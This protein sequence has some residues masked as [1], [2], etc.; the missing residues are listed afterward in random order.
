MFFSTQLLES[1]ELIFVSILA[2]FLH[3]TLYNSFV[4]LYHWSFFISW[5]LSFDLVCWLVALKKKL[6][7][8]SQ[9]I[10]ETS[11]GF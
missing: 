9:I 8:P 5:L 4:S 10:S 2:A 3:S 7:E 6:L 11:G 1:S